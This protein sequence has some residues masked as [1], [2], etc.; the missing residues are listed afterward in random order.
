MLLARKNDKQLLDIEC[1]LETDIKRTMDWIWDVTKQSKNCS[2]L[3]SV[4][5]ISNSSFHPFLSS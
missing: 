3:I 2:L 1:T 5:F 4:K